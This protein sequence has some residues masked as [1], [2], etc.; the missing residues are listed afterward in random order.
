MRKTAFLGFFIGIAL[1][2]LCGAVMTALI[3]SWSFRADLTGDGALARIRF[4]IS[5]DAFTDR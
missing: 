4:D 1:G 3:T 2:C 5:I